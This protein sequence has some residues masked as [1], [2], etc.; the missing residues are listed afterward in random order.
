[1]CVCERRADKPEG[2]EAV[3]AI[4]VRSSVSLNQGHGHESVAET[5][6]AVMRWGGQGR[7]EEGRF[8]GGGIGVLC[9]DI[10][11]QMCIV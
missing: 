4:W 6:S 8:A 3:A 10:E 7:L 1:M 11:P 5:E 2:R 9:L